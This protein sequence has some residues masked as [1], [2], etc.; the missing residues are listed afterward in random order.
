MPQLLK[1]F[2]CQVLIPTQPGSSTTMVTWAQISAEN[3][4]R[5]RL[6]LETQYGRKNV[7]GT[8]MEVR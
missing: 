5:A 8:P 6:M 3:Y 7:I 2:Q 4:H 1:T